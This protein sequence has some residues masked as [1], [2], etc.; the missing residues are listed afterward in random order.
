M[1]LVSGDL[2]QTTVAI[3]AADTMPEPIEN[4]FDWFAISA[5]PQTNRNDV[6][7][8]KPSDVSSVTHSK[9][10]VSRRQ[11]EIQLVASMVISDI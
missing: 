11:A 9:S 8:L 6:T 1:P 4:G 5:D 2:R 7:A 3:T 10:F